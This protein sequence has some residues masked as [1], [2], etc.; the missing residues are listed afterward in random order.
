MVGLMGG[1]LERGLSETLS[2]FQIQ[3]WNKAPA[4]RPGLDAGGISNRREGNVCC[5]PRLH[6][7]PSNLI[8]G[9]DLL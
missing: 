2:L 9:L 5:C 1:L 7:L 6:F 3:T 4:H 8:G